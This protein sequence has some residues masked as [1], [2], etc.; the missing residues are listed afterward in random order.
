MSDSDDDEMFVLACKVVRFEGKASNTFL[1]KKLGVGTGRAR[2]L[3]ARMEAVGLI[4][5]P[6]RLG[7][8][9]VYPSLQDQQPPQE[10]PMRAD[11]DDPEDLA[12]DE[13][14]DGD[15]EFEDGATA[16]PAP[17]QVVDP[18]Y[19]RAVK[20]VQDEN[21]CSVSF[22]QRV[23]ALGYNAAARLVERMEREGVVSKPDHL[24]KR[25]VFHVA[26]DP[27]RVAEPDPAPPVDEAPP[28]PD[29]LHPNDAQ[30]AAADREAGKKPHNAQAP[31][32]NMVSGTELLGYAER[33]ER[34]RERIAAEKQA[35]ADIFAE[36]KGRGHDTTVFKNILKERSQK[37]SAREEQMALTDLYRAA[38]GMSVEPPLFRFAG[39]GFDPTMRD[40]VTQAFKMIVPVDGE[41]IFRAPG[42]N[43]LIKRTREGGVE[44]G[45]APPPGPAPEAAA[46]APAAPA[47]PDEVANETNE[48]AWVLGAKA[49]KDD[50]SIVRNPFPFGDERR[51]HWDEGWRAA[52][53]EE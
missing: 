32:S 2:A 37:P 21:K 18:L 34:Q 28:I 12:E 27:A 7:E 38:M 19:V 47:V 36:L 48:G 30:E 24:G 22:I 46:P 42:M 25:V 40:M 43:L 4:S 1:Q 20:V 16:V 3:L 23:L 9:T 44:V 29:D 39:L 11:D 5:P 14:G 31:G 52:D 50:L 33:I 49:R 13:S 51:Q 17:E 53:G 8:R 6:G 26:E 41:I 45:E 35:E 10:P 15:G